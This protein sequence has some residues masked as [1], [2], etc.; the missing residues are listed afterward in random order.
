MPQDVLSPD[1]LSRIRALALE[2]VAAMDELEAA[3][4][5]NDVPRVFALARRIVALE[6]QV[7]Q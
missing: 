3:L 1:M 7:E 2:Q 4:I 6:K 5:A